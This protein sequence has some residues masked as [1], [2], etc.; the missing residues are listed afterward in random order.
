M[1]DYKKILSK[2]LRI[3]LE[4]N[5]KPCNLFAD[6]TN[7]PDYDDILNHVEPRILNKSIGNVITMTPTEYFQR[8][9][10]L[11]DTSLE[12]QY[13]F[14]DKSKVEAI[15]KNMANGNR[16][17]MPYLDY[18]QNKGQEGRHRVKA[19][20]ELG[21]ENIPVLVV[22]KA[23]EEIP[24]VISN[25]DQPTE[26][27]SDKVGTWSDLSQQNNNLL[28]T[29]EFTSPVKN[30]ILPFIRLYKG[31]HED[32]YFDDCLDI[33]RN[34][35][36]LE[37]RKPVPHELRPHDANKRISNY[38]FDN[39]PPQLSQ[40]LKSII[41]DSNSDFNEYSCG[42]KRDVDY[43]FYLEDNPE[44][45]PELAEYIRV[46]LISIEHYMILKNN[47]HAFPANGSF[48]YINIYRNKAELYLDEDGFTFDNL[49]D[50]DS[51]KNYIEH[52]IGP[53]VDMKTAKFIDNVEQ[54]PLNYMEEYLAKYP[55]K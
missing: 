29:Y 50:Y 37:L 28:I 15:K 10:N 20:Q 25:D 8:C 19:A 41:C 55:I 31:D 27:L 54:I 44:M 49:N 23:G 53:I 7:L 32:V 22:Y 3:L 11:Q 16:Y 12:D 40:M 33:I 36:K 43:A 52:E 30:G 14:I 18:A 38:S 4:S 9:A 47:T 21:C 6:K 34:L 35:Q 13:S 1:F 17:N 39:L 48:F 24:T 46:M 26:K 51:A 5:N 45:A 2:R 42:N